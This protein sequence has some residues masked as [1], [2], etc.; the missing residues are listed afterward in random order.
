M[1]P[2]VLLILAD[3]LNSWIGALGR[4]PNVRT[5]NIDALAAQGALFS[6]A[7]C[8]APYCNASRMGIFTGCLPSTTGIYHD[9]PLWDRADRPITLVE[10][11]REGGYYTFGAG[12]VFHGVFDYHEAGRRGADHAE[13]REI[14]NRPAIWSSFHSNDAEPLPAERPLNRLF[15]F[16]DFAAVPPMY[17]HFDW[18][19]IPED[20]AGEMPDA[21]V[22]GAVT[23][24]LREPHSEPFFCAAGLYKPHL[25]WHVPARFF[26]AYPL[27]RVALPLV[28]DDDLD[29]VPP[30]ARDWA[31]S[32]PDHALVTGRGQWAAAVRGYLAAISYCDHIV[33][34][35][36]TALRNSGLAENTI[37]VFC[38]DNGFHL[39]EK[40]HWRKF[41]L[42]E[43]ATRVPLIIVWPGRVPQHHRIQ[44]PVSLVDL[45]PT[46]L[47]LCGVSSPHGIDGRSLG[48]MLQ[49]SSATRSAPAVM[50]WGRGNHSVRTAAWRFT[51]YSDGA[52]ELYDHRLDPYEWNNLA[53]TP[54]FD[55]V[56]RNLRQFL[57]LDH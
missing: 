30:I 4:H 55:A 53:L 7:Y 16:G 31:L 22:S 17:H 14:E 15:D 50:S 10:R 45:F 28:R 52:E 51:R 47:E 23:E 3:D 32:P 37:I 1:T 57:P 46:I 34:Q 9:E 27:D 11:L 24:F 6:H 48:E 29:D 56:L 20:R 43:E 36:V 42:W 39:G 54:E 38:G 49:G 12:K 35:I 25:P 5:P 40:L 8:S 19:P 2:N 18:G 13:W 41:A 33:G 26:E 44:E 21:K